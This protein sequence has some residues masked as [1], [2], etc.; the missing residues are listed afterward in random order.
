MLFRRAD[1]IF[2]RF[3]F[4]LQKMLRRS[5][6]PPSIVTAALGPH[7]RRFIGV[8]SKPTVDA[9]KVQPQRTED[10]KDAKW[11]AMSEAERK[12]HC[13]KQDA[14]EGKQ[15]DSAAGRY[16]V[17]NKDEKSACKESSKQAGAECKTEAP[18]AKE[19]GKQAGAECK[20]EA[21]KAKEGAPAAPK[22]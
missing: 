16:D 8:E 1:F 7:C 2:L 13:L 18:K 20:T 10:G 9:A 19:G 17:T 21:P 22:K 5:F 12:E 4:L 11:Q 6:L 3:Y 15:F 14:K